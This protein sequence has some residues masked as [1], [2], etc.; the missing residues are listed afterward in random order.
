M[1]LFKPKKE[2]RGPPPSYNPIVVYH[3]T[4]S[5]D[6]RLTVTPNPP[7]YNTYNIFQDKPKTFRDSIGISVVHANGGVVGHCVTQVSSGK[8]LDFSVSENRNL[9]FWHSG[10]GSSSKYILGTTPREAKWVHD[11]PSGST[12]SD[13][14]LKLEDGNGVLA[15]FAGAGDS[16]SEFGRLEIYQ[17]G[18]ADGVDWCE[19][20]I[21]TA[22]SVYLGEE[23]QREARNKSRRGTRALGNVGILLS[24]LGG[25]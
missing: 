17:Q 7:T 10:H 1:G 23:R 13:G 24:V 22:V 20:V 19:L 3:I 12:K 16:V 2:E 9:N 11:S 8:V 14:R 21:L 4:H 25:S 18:Q 15:R 6:G 5:L